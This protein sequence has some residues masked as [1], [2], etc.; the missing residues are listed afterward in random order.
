[1]STL[2]DTYGNVHF[3]FADLAEEVGGD[4]RVRTPSP[5]GNPESGQLQESQF[6]L[7]KRKAPT[8]PG[9]ARYVHMFVFLVASL[10]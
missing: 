1:M 9:E 6:V 7:G 2:S 4:G 3:M 8:T 10:F 5:V